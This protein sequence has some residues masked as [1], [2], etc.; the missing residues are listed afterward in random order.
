MKPVSGPR[1]MARSRLGPT[2]DGTW[3]WFDLVGLDVLN[4]Q[5]ENLGKVAELMQ[6]GADDVLVLQ[7]ERRRLIPF[8]HGTVVKAVD[9]DAGLV[10]VDWDS[11]F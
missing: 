10:R 1:W 2:E 8:V 6:T 9:L 3:Y 11:E 5:G 7:G 4:E